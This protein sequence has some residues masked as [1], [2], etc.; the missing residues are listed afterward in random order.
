[1]KC[2]VAFLVAFS[3]SSG[4][5]KATTSNPVFGVGSESCSTWL[6]DRAN[7]NWYVDVQWV[8]G[9][10]TP[11]ALF[12]EAGS[13]SDI[14]FAGYNHSMWTW[15]DNYCRSNPKDV[16]EGAAVNFFMKSNTMF[17]KQFRVLFISNL[18]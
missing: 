6:A 7:D 9:F 11:A 18:Q 3:L 10:L 16:L 15:I 12:K 4:I 14:I 8:Y 2:V 13:G 17:E 5:A 1:M